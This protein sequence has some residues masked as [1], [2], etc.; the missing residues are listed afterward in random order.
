MKLKQILEKGKTLFNSG[1]KRS[2]AVALLLAVA[3]IF[4]FVNDPAIVGVSATTRQ[5]PIYCV[6]RDGKM[7]SLTF[8]A[9]WGNTILRYYKCYIQI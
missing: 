7:V 3:A 8:D 9:A 5:L 6:Q 4:W 2:S 1:K